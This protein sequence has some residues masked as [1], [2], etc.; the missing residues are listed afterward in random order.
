M[1]CNNYTNTRFNCTYFYNIIKIEKHKATEL[2][3]K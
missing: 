3:K 2:Y 1:N